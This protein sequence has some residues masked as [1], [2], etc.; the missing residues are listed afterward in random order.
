MVLA[1]RPNVPG[2]AAADNDNNNFEM[3][4]AY[5]LNTVDVEQRLF[6]ELIRPLVDRYMA[7]F[8]ATVRFNL[9]E[10]LQ[11]LPFSCPGVD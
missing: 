4:R 9:T 7:G 3:E 10:S 1:P 2:L 5:L 8:N 11:T 6:A